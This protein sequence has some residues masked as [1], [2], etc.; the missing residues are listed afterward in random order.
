M[1]RLGTGI[2]LNMET[3]TI[4]ANG[5][6]ISLDDLPCSIAQVLAQLNMN[7][8]SVVVELNGQAVVNSQFWFKT[9]NSGDKMEIVKIVAGG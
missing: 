1:E 8:K 7:P 4:V 5:E 9:V 6:L 3:G 2:E